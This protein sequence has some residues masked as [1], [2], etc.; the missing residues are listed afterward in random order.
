[1]KLKNCLFVLLHAFITIEIL[2]SCGQ[3]ENENNVAVGNENCNSTI[4]TAE[5][6]RLEFPKLRGGT[7][8]IVVVHYTD[9]YGLNYAVEW[10]CSKRAQRWTCY[11]MYNAN[12]VTNWN[13]NNWDGV[14]WDGKKWF[15]DPFQ[16]DS[17]IPLSYRTTLSDYKGSGYNRGHIC[18]SAD[19]LCSMEANG[20]TFYLSNM[21]PQYG[22]FNSGIWLEME[23]KVRSWNRSTFRD[24]LY[25]CK[26]GTIEDFGETRGVLT[27][28]NS[29]LIVPRYFFMAILC[30]RGSSYKAIGFW[31]EHLNSDHSMDKLSQ[32]VV[33]IDELERK[34]GIDF[35]CN[36]PDDVESR[37]EGLDQASIIRAW[38]LK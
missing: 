16:E 8:N 3:A 7:Q 29:G 4:V 6:G 18:P 30:E 17:E 19:R 2:T 12:S 34:T 1:M 21:Q 9:G 15:G 13:R 20:Q 27:H 28:T 5:A 10:D 35:F 36:L 38:G 26:G 32:Y 23:N 24:V 11:S 37:V 14:Y 25:V 31:V 22:A 33:S